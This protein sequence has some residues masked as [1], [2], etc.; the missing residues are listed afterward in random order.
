MATPA[1]SRYQ[2]RDHKDGKNS[3]GYRTAYVSSNLDYSRPLS[4]SLRSILVN[5]STSSSICPENKESKSSPRDASEKTPASLDTDLSDKCL[6]TT[7]LEDNKIDIDNSK[8]NLN[9]KISVNIDNL[10][11]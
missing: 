6:S 3:F 10:L 9:A 5:L 11:D 2:D 4:N 1:A 8:I 7:D